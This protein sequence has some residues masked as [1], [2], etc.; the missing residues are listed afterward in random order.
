MTDTTER[1]Y[2]LAWTQ[3]RGI[4]AKSQ[5]ALCD[6]FGSMTAA[7]TASAAELAAIDGFGAKT[8]AS[9]VAQRL[10]INPEHLYAS[11]TNANPNFWTLGDDDYPTLLRE[12]PLPPPILHY[13]GEP[14]SEDL[15]GQRPSVA[16]VGTRSPSEY[17]KRWT[18]RLTETLV[19]KG[20]TILSGMAAGIDAIA[21]ETCLRHNGRTIAVFGT[22]VDVIYPDSNRKLYTAIRDQGLILSEY[23]AQT[24]PRREHF[25]ARNR[26]VA[27]LSRATI[28]TEAP[29]RSG[30]LITARLANDYGR[31]AIAIPGTL[32]D[33]NLRGCNR[34]IADGAAQ[35]VLDEQHLLDLL[36]GLPGLDPQRY[37]TTNPQTRQ[38]PPN[39]PELL[40]R[41]L[42][43]VPYEPITID[44][45]AVT[46]GLPGGEL[47][48]ALSQLELMDWIIQL[49][50]GMRY[51]RC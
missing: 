46:L 6:Q 5:R 24:P 9:I 26:I 39:F 51:Q 10:T 4:G 1:M 13:L 17:G 11:Y 31:E 8:V 19:D 36:S 34:L 47:L 43:A 12:S 27:A 15:T 49:P 44:Q 18:R 41:V 16:I 22:G 38:I 29:E 30:A 25:P 2:W 14:H 20:F 45:L 37:T 35:L 28:V 33:P 48:A 42:E 7:W 50:G 23:P 40:R 21:H 32:D 3:L